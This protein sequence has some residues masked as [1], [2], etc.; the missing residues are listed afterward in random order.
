LTSAALPR[1]RSVTAALSKSAFVTK[2][3]VR[4]SSFQ[5]HW[6]FGTF[7]GSVLPLATLRGSS[8]VVE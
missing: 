2:S 8:K 4:I 7:A 5:R 3:G 1:F 6:S